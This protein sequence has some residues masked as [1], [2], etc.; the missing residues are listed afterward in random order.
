MFT[1][2]YELIHDNTTESKR[3]INILQRMNI[4]QEV[5]L[6][7]LYRILPIQV[8]NH[9]CFLCKMHLLGFCRIS[10]FFSHPVCMCVS[11]CFTDL[12]GTNLF[13]HL[14]SVCFADSVCHRP[15]LSLVGYSVTPGWQEHSVVSGTFSTGVCAQSVSHTPKTQL[16]SQSGVNKCLLWC[17]EHLNSDKCQSRYISLKCELKLSRTALKCS[18]WSSINV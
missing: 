14:H 18:S 17:S 10:L 3:T 11:V 13:L 9:F 5:F 4:Y 2:L 1:G 16:C 12:L 7:I 15:S 8:F 6:S